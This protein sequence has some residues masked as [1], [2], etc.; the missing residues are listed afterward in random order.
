MIRLSVKNDINDIISVWKEAFGDSEKDIEFFLNRKYIPENTVV[1]EENGKVVS[2]LF[3]LNGFMHI[4]G[5]DYPSYY[6][7]A[8]CT[9]EVC[10]GK[11]IMAKMLDY[12]KNL[13]K[14]RGVEF[15]CLRPGEKSLFNY[16]EKQGYK[17]VFYSKKAFLTAFPSV[18]TVSTLN[19]SLESARNKA[20]SGINY[21]KWDNES[22]NFAIEHNKYF[23]GNAFTNCNGYLLYTVNH[24]NIYVKEY[25][26]TITESPCFSTDLLSSDKLYNVTF[27]LPESANTGDLEFVV[28]PDGMAISCGTLDVEIIKNGYLGL[29]LE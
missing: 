24:Q 11:G 5:K 20:F 9:S 7:Y 13:A 4:N 18:E 3:L 10:R 17:T 2:V 28:E 6:L 26:F 25:T 1:C 21:F 12:S 19:E 14:N 23:G 29:T 27:N 8:A 22:I 15:I 16:Y